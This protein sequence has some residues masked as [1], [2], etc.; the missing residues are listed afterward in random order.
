MSARLS[1]EIWLEVMQQFV[2]EPRHDWWM[3]AA[4]EEILPLL[5]VSKQWQVC[6]SGIILINNLSNAK[7]Q[8]LSKPLLYRYLRILSISF[9]RKLVK[10]FDTQQAHGKD[11]GRWVWAI[12]IGIGNSVER[13]RGLTSLIPRC[14]NLR[15]ADCMYIG[16]FALLSLLA[17]T[18]PTMR[19]M[20]IYLDPHD[21]PS[22]GQIDGFKHLQHFYIM[23]CPGR[24]ITHAHNTSASL[25]D[26]PPWRL[27]ELQ[28]LH[29]V[30]S[31]DGKHVDLQYLARWSFPKLKSFTMDRFEESEAEIKH[32][33]GFLDAHPHITC[34]SL[35][36]LGEM[37][38]LMS[39]VRSS[40]LR[41][42]LRQLGEVSRTMVQLLRPE[43]VQLNLSY[44]DYCA[45]AL[46][47]FLDALCMQPK[48]VRCVHIGMHIDRT[49]YHQRE[50][51]W[52]EQH[53]SRMEEYTSVLELMGVQLTQDSSSWQYENP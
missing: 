4:S 9:M 41:L 14:L 13:T 33:A 24:V 34:L 45:E 17:L 31:D 3:I 52:I 26:V 44:I 38:P 25:S 50:K 6:P 20:N 11:C 18:G 30:P 2:S 15:R 36:G 43:V 48:G 42:G 53:R 1:E 27:P 32:L 47:T 40:E 5:L 22:M 29:L 19:T 8:R 23:C 51:D 10:A 49:S 37:L 21:H 39:H 12:Y 7:P 16:N 46:W 28:D 35:E